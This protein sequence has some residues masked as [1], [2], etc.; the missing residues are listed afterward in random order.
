MFLNEFEK[1]FLLLYLGVEWI[2]G[3]LIFMTNNTGVYRD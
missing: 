2:T 3:R 1:F